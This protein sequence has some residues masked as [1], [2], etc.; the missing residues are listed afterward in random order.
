MLLMKHMQF[1]IE[2]AVP[3]PRLPS[4]PPPPPPLPFLS[5]VPASR[6]LVPSASVASSASPFPSRSLAVDSARC[7]GSQISFLCTFWI[8]SPFS[9][10]RPLQYSC[11]HSLRCL[12]PRKMQLRTRPWPQTPASF[13]RRRF[14]IQYRFNTCEHQPQVS[15]CSWISTRLLFFYDSY[16]QSEE[17]QD[18]NKNTISRVAWWRLA[19]NW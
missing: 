1:V 7:L 18:A 16:L 2:N 14:A 11:W 9:V 8:E 4:H 19:P 13:K 17:G 5:L 15:S 12:L 10:L 3:R 6:C